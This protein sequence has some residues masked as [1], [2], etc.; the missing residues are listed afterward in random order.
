MFFIHLRFSSAI[1]FYLIF[2]CAIVTGQKNSQEYDYYVDNFEPNKDE[3]FKSNI[4]SVD[5]HKE[6][7]V[8]SYPIIKL[9]DEVR[10]ILRFDDLGDEFPVYS[11]TIRQC[12]ADWETSELNF[13]E[14]ANGFEENVINDYQSS[15]NTI[16]DYTHYKVIIPNNDVQITKSGNYVIEVFQDYNRENLVLR[17]R[18][19]VVENLVEINADI[20]KAPWIEQRMSGQKINVTLR[21]PGYNITNPNRDITMVIL[22]NNIWEL[23]NRNLKPRFIRGNEILY[24]YEKENVF[25]G[26]NQFRYFDMK[27]K[28]FKSDR[29][30][31]IY[32]AR[33][34]YHFQLIEDRV[35]RNS[36]FSFHEDINGKRFIQLEGSEESHVE[37]DYFFAHFT[38]SYPAPLF[39]ANVYVWG[40]L[41]GWELNESNK[42]TYSIE[43][44][45][46]ELSLFLKQG[47]YNYQ[48]VVVNDR[49]KLDNTYIEG[50]YYQT[51]ND[52]VIY[53]YHRDQSIR[54]DRLIGMRIV[55]SVNRL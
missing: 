9:N 15:F 1:I 52:Y 43:R 53:I 45:A 30:E 37:A 47:Y 31:K 5:L 18:F 2:T 13:S 21:H 24:D 28:R 20:D 40:E 39:D 6:S 42:L 4:H 55:N 19:C 16:R 35:R 51:E 3:V 48:Y 29:V 10:L 33:P 36:P 27:N 17:R 26:S 34:Y 49:N 22:Q 7:W 25:E 32:F 14:F 8:L 46:Y 50:S 38:L 11:Y 44:K 23:A 41:T 54:Y 12:D